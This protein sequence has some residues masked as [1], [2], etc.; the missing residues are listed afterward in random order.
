MRETD[1]VRNL[2]SSGKQKMF[3]GYLVFLYARQE[4]ICNL[5]DRGLLALGMAGPVPSPGRQCRLEAKHE[6]SRV[7]MHGS[8]CWLHQLGESFILMSFLLC[9]MG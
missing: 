8:K 9:E 5:R 4:A 2:E 6:S 7:R 3:S 1:I